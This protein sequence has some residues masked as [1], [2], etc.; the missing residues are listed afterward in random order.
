[1]AEAVAIMEHYQKAYRLQ[2]EQWEQV[3]LRLGNLEQQ[4]QPLREERKRIESQLQ[5]LKGLIEQQAQIT[6]NE[7]A[8]LSEET[9][10]S[11]GD[12]VRAH[13]EKIL[14]EL[15]QPTSVRVLIEEFRRRGYR[16]P[17]AGRSNNLTSHI[18]RGSSR[19]VCISRGVYGLSDWLDR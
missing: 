5:A 7:P 1:M 12:V 6:D 10:L 3:D 9:R 13:T 18:R 17:G 4:A 16:L 19:I 14:E 2:V 8:P 11:S 15:D